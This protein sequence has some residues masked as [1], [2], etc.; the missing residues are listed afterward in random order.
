M[1]SFCLNGC[2]PLNNEQRGRLVTAAANA[3]SMPDYLWR[4]EGEMPVLKWDQH[5][6][7]WLDHRIA[8][9][10]LY[11]DRGYSLLPWSVFDALPDTAK[12]SQIFA[13]NQ[14]TVPSCSMHGAAHAYQTAMLT[15]IALGAPLFYEAMNPIYSFYGAR[16]GNLNGGLDLWT[17]A[18]WIN[19]NGMIPASIAGEDN[20]SVRQE[21]L[22]FLDRGKKWQAGIVLIEDQ[23]EEKIVR[24]CRGLCSVSFGSGRLFMSSYTDR[25]GVK[26]MDGIR[27]GGHAQC[28]TGYRKI[29]NSDYLFNVNSYGNIY[30]VSDEGEPA[31]GAW[32]GREQLRVYTEDMAVYGFPYLVFCEG[33]F[34]REPS[35]TNE[36]EL[37][38]FPKSFRM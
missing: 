36:F 24:A 9:A 34:R 19:R 31:C 14:G 12:H 3:V 30:G 35:L 11:R 25:N 16:N 32:L 8:L 33:E 37:P 27:Q 18:D 26:V 22:K 20:Q 4:E 10:D 15:A 28:L 38:R 6:D 21:N 1:N 17:A 2:L 5:F 13:W 29:G 23:F 7:E